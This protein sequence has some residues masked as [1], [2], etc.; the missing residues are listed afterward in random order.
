MTQRKWTACARSDALREGEALAVVVDGREVA[1]YRVEGAVYATDDR[2]TH[3]DARLSEGFMMDHCVECPLHQGQF[4]VRTG[5]P[6]CEPVTEPVAV[7]AVREV[8]GAIE[9][10]LDGR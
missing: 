2:C 10:A 5:A 3:G 8:D 6:L 7:H 4:D 9:V 1:L